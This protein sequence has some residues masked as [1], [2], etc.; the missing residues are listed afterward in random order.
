MANGSKQKNYGSRKLICMIYFFLRSLLWLFALPLGAGP[1]LVPCSYE[2]VKIVAS[3]VSNDKKRRFDNEL[4]S[5][6]L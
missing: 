6:I 3:H 5:L 2:Y 4:L 1:I